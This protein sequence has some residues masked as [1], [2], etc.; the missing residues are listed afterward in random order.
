M[1]LD[2]QRRWD[3]QH[4]DFR[5]DTEPSGFLRQIIESEC[6]E[7]PRGRALDIACGQGRHALYLAAK[8]F[9]VVAVDISQIALAEGQK[10]AA[11]RSLTI[12]W[13]QADLLQVRLERDSF[14]LIVDFNYL[15]RS[16]IPQMKTALKNG[17]HVI[18]ETY[19]IDQRAIGHPKNPDYLLAH[20]ELLDRFRDFRAL[21]YRE[22]RFSDGGEPAF[23]AGLLARKIG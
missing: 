19:L 6:W 8:G 17:G 9:D 23:R 1:S 21:C 13:K 20:N 10:R 2:D 14:D 11:E 16:L 18:F 7:I 22:G 15:Q 3:K 12:S 4:A 5:S